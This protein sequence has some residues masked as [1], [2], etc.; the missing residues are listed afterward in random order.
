MLSE[1]EAV[2]AQDVSE[3]FCTSD[4]RGRRVCGEFVL[5]LGGSARPHKEEKCSHI[6]KNET[7]CLTLNSL[8]LY[9]Q[10]I[11]TSGEKEVTIVLT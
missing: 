1:E 6:G 9:N 10:I 8:E 4:N 3:I 5:K 7:G 2:D 11:R